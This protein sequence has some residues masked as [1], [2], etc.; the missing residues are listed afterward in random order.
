MCRS[1]VQHI[2]VLHL[3]LEEELNSS[4][5]HKFHDCTVRHASRSLASATWDKLSLYWVYRLYSLEES[6]FKINCSRRA[7]SVSFES[8]LPT[9]FFHICIFL[10]Y[11]R[12][13]TQSM[14]WSSSWIGVVR[15][16]MF[17]RLIV[18]CIVC[19]L[20]NSCVPENGIHTASTFLLLLLLLLLLLILLWKIRI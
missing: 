2:S 1:I 15:C 12:V 10:A 20:E 14:E 8:F 19:L 11:M 3:M 5:H 16:D 9:N 18:C 6:I 17:G 4:I 13:C 7:F